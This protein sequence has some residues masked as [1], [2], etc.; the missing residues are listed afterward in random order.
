MRGSECCSHIARSIQ[1]TAGIRISDQQNVVIERMRSE[2]VDSLRVLPL[3]NAREAWL[4]LLVALDLDSD[5]PDLGF[6]ESD[7]HVYSSVSKALDV[8]RDFAV[9]PNDRKKL[10]RQRMNARHKVAI[11]HQVL[12]RPQLRGSS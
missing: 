1:N 4:D 7:E 8:V 10:I 2:R 5:V 6:L 9:A 12:A 3:Q 11:V